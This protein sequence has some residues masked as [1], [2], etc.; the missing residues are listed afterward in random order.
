MIGESHLT[1]E[2]F[3]IQRNLPLNYVTREADEVLKDSLD[4]KHHVVIYG[5]SKQGKTS[6]RKKNLKEDDYIII[7]CSHKWDIYQLNINILKQVG[8]EIIVSEKKNYLW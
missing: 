3:G 1:K 5:S 2:V 8:F 4:R 7:H 6:L